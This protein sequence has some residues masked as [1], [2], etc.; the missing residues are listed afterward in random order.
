[1]EKIL[2][3]LKRFWPQRMVVAK[4]D[5][6][7]SPLGAAIGLIGTDLISLYFLGTENPWFIAPM[8]ASAVLLFAVPAS[9]LAQ[10]WPIVGGN[11]IAAIVGVTFAKFLG[12]SAWVAGLAGAIAIAGMMRFR[13]LHPPG[14]AVA[15]TAV[16]G[17]SGVIQLGYM[18]VILP[19]FLNSI[20]LML[21]ALI[22]N[23][24]AKRS[25]PHHANIASGPSNVQFVSLSRQDI[26]EALR[27]NPDLLDVSEGDIEAILNEAESIAKVNQAR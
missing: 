16:L 25:Y 1:M 8:G 17:G 4:R 14:G 3:W 7:I 11:L 15:L 23:N 12:T 19:V 5:Y 20:L 6:W 26:H 27:R 22:F 21:L 24:L 13:C 2:D 9:P 10:P 18:F